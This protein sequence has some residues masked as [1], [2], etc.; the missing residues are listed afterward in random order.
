MKFSRVGRADA[1]FMIL[2]VLTVAMRLRDRWPASP[3]EIAAVRTLAASNESARRIVSLR[4]T[5]DRD[6]NKGELRHLRE[7]VIAVETLA[8]RSNAGVHAPT[9][10]DTARRAKTAG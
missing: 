6:L 5:G 1:L 8:S 4:L 7:R 2:I 3:E 9:A 10:P